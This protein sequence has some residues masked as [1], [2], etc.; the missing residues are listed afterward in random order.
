MKRTL[1]LVVTTLLVFTAYSQNR[2]RHRI[3]FNRFRMP[4]V[5][6]FAADPDGKN[7]RPLVPHRQME[8]SPSISLNGQWVAFTSEI[9]GKADIWRVHPDGSGLEQL[10]HD[11]AFDDQGAISPD[12]SSLAFIS[13]REGGTANLW[14]LDITSRKYRNL[15]HNSAGSFRP[16]WS[17]DGKWIAFSSDLDA[18]PTVNTQ[19]FPG[20]WELLQ[21]TGIYII[22][23]DGTALRRLTHPGGVAGTPSWSAD[24]QSVLFYETDETGAYLAKSS[25]SRTEI[26][27]LDIATGKRHQY[28]ASAD[29]KLWPQSLPNGKIAWVVRSGT[30]SE[31]LKLWYPDR[32]ID[33]LAK[34]AVRNPSWSGD[35]KQ[36]VYAKILHPASTE[37]LIPTTSRDPE[38]ELFLS[39]PFPSFSPDGKRL[40]YSQYGSDGANAGDTS[41]E[42]MDADGASKHTLFHEKGSSAYDAVWSPS[43]ELIAFSVGH[44]F[45]SPGLPSAQIALIKPDGSGFRA[46]A[47]DGSNNGFPGWSPDGQRIVFRRGKKLMILTL[48]DNT[49]TALT[50]GSHYDNF[51]QWSPKGDAIMFTS[52]RDGRFEL[53]TLR[54]DGTNL[55][56]LTNT[57]GSSAHSIWSN[58]GEWIV[59]S[60]G[61]K[62]FKDEM[63]LYDGTPQPYGEIFA[64]HADGSDVRQLT[65]NK[66]E[67]ASA[68]WMPE[69]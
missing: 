30:E 59:F 60:S 32:K 55:R 43:G 48:A 58:N 54:P 15:S 29:T 4:E 25:R 39:E 13:T 12:G 28:T 24:G 38:F 18:S 31:G 14:L 53:Y 51:P 3:L 20:Q 22:H 57:P 23:P 6:I 26:V 50:D 19:L 41:V 7:E 9:A 62:G 47:D 45:R 1:C 36:L 10:T 2:T 56:R 49:V 42:I 66:W 64:M 44:Y 11:P 37:H 21:S 16:S 69:K 5:A 34:G 17:P 68:G 40:L 33:T 35:G 63:A 46:I 65:D 8:Y 27:S 61:R 67:D 52:D